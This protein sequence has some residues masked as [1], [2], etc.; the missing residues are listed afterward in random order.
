MAAFAAEIAARA[1]ALVEPFTV[2]EIDA[3]RNEGLLRT[4]PVRKQGRAFYYELH[5]HGA[6]ALTL[7]R[8]QAPVAGERREQVAF[9]LTNET[10]ARL[11]GEIAGA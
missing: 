6:A 4:R 10:L 9:A 2:Y 7:R 5:L 1:Q 8:F 3:T 11:V